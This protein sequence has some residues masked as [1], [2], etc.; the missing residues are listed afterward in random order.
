MQLTRPLKNKESKAFCPL[1]IEINVIESWVFFPKVCGNSM[2][3]WIVRNLNACHIIISIHNIYYCYIYLLFTKYW[4]YPQSWKQN[5]RGD[6]SFCLKDYSLVF[7]VDCPRMYNIYSHGILYSPER[8]SF[9]SNGYISNFL[10]K[11]VVKKYMCK[12]DIFLTPGNHK[13]NT[14]NF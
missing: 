7:S 9:P 6:Y 14:E 12:D 10:K 1:K 3:F 2:H 5:S 8:G 4:R 11:Y 13:Q